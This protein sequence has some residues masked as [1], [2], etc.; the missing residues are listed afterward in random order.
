MTGHVGFLDDPAK[1][2][3]GLDRKFEEEKSLAPS[4]PRIRSPLCG[5]SPRKDDLWSCTCGDEWNQFRYGRSVPRLPTPVD[6][7]P[8]FNINICRN[9]HEDVRQLTEYAH[10]HRLATDYHINETPM[11]KQDEHFK[12]LNGNPTYIRPEE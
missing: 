9:N 11:L 3:V 2:S 1:S 8:I 5:W 4:G 6:F 7:N 10:A 12:H